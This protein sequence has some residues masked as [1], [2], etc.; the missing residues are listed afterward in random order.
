MQIVPL[1]YCKKL[2]LSVEKANKLLSDCYDMQQQQ[3]V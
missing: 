2:F 1:I 3:T